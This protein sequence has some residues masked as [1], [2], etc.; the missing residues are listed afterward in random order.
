MDAR[1]HGLVGMTGA[2]L[3]RF[4]EGPDFKENVKAMLRNI[5][6]EESPE[7][8]RTIL[9][10]DTD[11]I[12]AIVAAL[13]SIINVLI[14]AAD[15]MIEE[16]NEKFSPELLRGFAKSLIDDIDKESAKR[17]VK[18]GTAIWTV[19]SPLFVELMRDIQMGELPEGEGGD[20]GNRGNTAKPWQDDR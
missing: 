1:T 17:I 5:N 3:E 8:V 18:N 6:P 20:H 19:L 13:P 2:V 12:L 14:R 9:W 7:L 16:V 4:L 10:K 11:L 15:M